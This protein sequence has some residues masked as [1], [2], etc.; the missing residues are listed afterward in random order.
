MASSFTQDSA[1]QPAHRASI[2][3]LLGA[4]VT[5]LAIRVAI[6]EP[7]IVNLNFSFTGVQMSLLAAMLAGAFIIVRKPTAAL[8]VLVTF[9]YLNLSEVL[10][11]EYRLPSLLQF[12]VL[13]VIV[14]VLLNEAGSVRRLFRNPVACLILGYTLV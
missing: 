7:E 3:L 11:R 10:V 13:P 8:M 12:L 5:V 1:T 2:A 4:I 14:S 9:V 6:A